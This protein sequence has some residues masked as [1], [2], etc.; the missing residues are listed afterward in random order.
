MIT[1]KA[2]K[3]RAFKCLGF[4]M[5]VNKSLLNILNLFAHLFDQYFQF[6]S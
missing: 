3:N 2:R 5:K 6:N 4:L 1:K